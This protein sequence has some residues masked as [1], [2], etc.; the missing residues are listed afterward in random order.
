MSYLET[1]VCTIPQISKGFVQS[2]DSRARLEI[3]ADALERAFDEIQVV[4]IVQAKG[5]KLGM[6]GP[7]FAR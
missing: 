7:V 5:G 6:G 2:N 3:P 4:E 1:L